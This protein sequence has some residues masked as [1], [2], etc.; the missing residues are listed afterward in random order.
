M[1]LNVERSK[2]VPMSSRG[3]NGDAGREGDTLNHTTENIKDS[4]QG[5]GAE[6]F[7]SINDTVFLVS[8]FLEFVNS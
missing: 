6:I 1:E 7:G 5:E 8:F 3:L 2:M 4:N